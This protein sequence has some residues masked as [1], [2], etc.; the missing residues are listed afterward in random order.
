M[1]TG[2][3]KPQLTLI[4]AGG[5]ISLVRDPQTGKSVPGLS[6]MDLL[7]R[8]GV[9]EAFTV[10]VIDLVERTKPLCRLQEL[11]NLARSIQQAAEA[12]DGVV[13]THGTDTLEEV[14][15][16]V[17]ETVAALVPI[18]FT[19]AMR[20][21]WASGYDG[22]RNLENALRV[23]AT[24][25]AEYG[26]LV[27]MHDEIF[28]A[29]SVY[30]AD[31]GALNAFTAR[32]GAA[33]GCIFGD[34]IA[35]TWRPLPRTRFGKI[36]QGLPASVPILA[37]GVGDD[38][39]AFDYLHA[40]KVQGLVVVSMA[41]GTV[42]PAAYDKLLLLA[43][44]GLPIVLCSGATSGRTAEEYYYPKAYDEL[45]AA[46]VAIED[47]LSPRKARVRLMLSIGLAVPYVPLGGGFITGS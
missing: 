15:Y 3:S 26:T 9:A 11:L 8:T 16:F 19:G 32:R 46:G 27:T 34:Q 41:A 2:N 20:P 6:G 47:W 31:T 45:R 42:P 10:R 14:A 5:T 24:V 40:A 38:G 4:T 28:A 18:V 33:I 43:K 29:W 44:T 22:L 13:V 12:S 25:S 23:A 36:P 17:D 30:K 35:L 1:K 39:V 7:Q 37:M 21:S